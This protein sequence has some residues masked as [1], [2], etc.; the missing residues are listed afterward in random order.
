MA[1]NLYELL[2]I[3]ETAS[4]EAIGANF[5]RLQAKYAAQA[6]DGDESARNQLIALR[7]AHDTLSDP[8]RR[9]RYDQRLAARSIPVAALE[10]GQRPLLPLIFVLAIALLAG[11]GYAKYSADQEKARLE[12]EKIVAAEKQAELEAQKEREDKQAAEQAERQRRADDAKERN[13]RARDIAYG[14]QVT[15]DIQRAETQVRYDRQREE[16]QRANEERQRVSEANRQLA[17]DKA[18]LR[19]LEADSPRTRY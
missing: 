10:S 1:G 9:Q 8:Q 17:K 13:D 18:Y 15:R 4:P 19:Q 5:K 16:Q 14:A 6:A 11:L 2:E 7:E 12:R 3:N